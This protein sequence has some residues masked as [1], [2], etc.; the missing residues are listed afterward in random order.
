[1]KKNAEMFVQSSCHWW[2]VCGCERGC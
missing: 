2:L 1:M